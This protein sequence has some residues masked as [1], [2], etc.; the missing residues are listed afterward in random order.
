M[1]LPVSHAKIA[2]TVV[3]ED[4]I[5]LTMSDGRE[6]RLSV[7]DDSVF[8]I[9]SYCDSNV[10]LEPVLEAAN[11]ARVRGFKPRRR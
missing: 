4:A 5:C 10:R 1:T 3:E 8:M 7:V 2:K 11:I 9:F 6:L